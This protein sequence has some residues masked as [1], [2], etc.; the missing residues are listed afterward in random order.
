MLDVVTNGKLATAMT[1][2][3]KFLSDDEINIVVDFVRQEFMAQ[4]LENTRYHTLENGWPEHDKYQAA[5]PFA[6]GEIALDVNQQS[7]TEQQRLGLQLYLGSCITCHDNSK[8]ENGGDI[9]STQAISYPRN[10]FSFTNFDGFTGASTYQK[11][12]TFEKL[13]DASKQQT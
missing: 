7:L 6:T 13:D 2:F 8:V 4:Q 12:D 10:N 11:H 5:F 9:W 1:G 3:S